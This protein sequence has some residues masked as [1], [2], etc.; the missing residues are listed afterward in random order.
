MHLPAGVIVTISVLTTV[1][2]VQSKSDFAKLEDLTVPVSRLSSSC[3]LSPGRSQGWPE[4]RVRG[5]VRVGLPITSNP[6]V[7]SDGSIVVAIRQ[8]V[9][10]V[11]R[12]VDGPPLD[13]RGL[14]A[15]RRRL[16][17]GVE[18]AYAAVYGSGEPEYVVVC[19]VR[20]VSATDAD[21]ESIAPRR[22]TRLVS[23][24]TVVDVSGDR[25]PCFSAVEAYV[26]SMVSR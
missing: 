7:G 10:G 24:R 23:G 25:S 21:P 4:G 15:F 26:R 11:A 16:A 5:G 14:A 1:L 6:W 17:D 12:V 22:S 9:E 13:A 8:H 3:G 20:F 18:A 2:T 19:A